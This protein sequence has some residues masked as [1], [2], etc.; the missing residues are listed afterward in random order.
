MINPF[1]SFDLVH[2]VQGQALY[3]NSL[4][5]NSLTMSMYIAGLLVL[6]SRLC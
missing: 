6:T 5:C 2:G 1:V 3:K 4:L